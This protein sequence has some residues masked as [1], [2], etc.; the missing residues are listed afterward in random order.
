MTRRLPAFAALA[1]ALAACETGSERKPAVS[2]RLRTTPPDTI[3]PGDSLHMSA[4]VINRER[5]PLTLEFESQCQVEM[6]VVTEDKSIVH[7]P[8]GGSTCISTPT[9]MKVPANDS[10][11]VDDA[12]LAAAPQPGEYAAYA[13]VSSH[14][15][16]RGERRDHK[17]SHRSN[18]VTFHVARPPS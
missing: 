8:G 18:I 15:V 10:V 9:A 17:L 11:R 14:H 12:W 1:V 2:V 4:W 7:P 16:V 6:F 3:A 13:V 5:E